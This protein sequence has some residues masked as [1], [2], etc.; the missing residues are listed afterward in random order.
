MSLIRKSSL[1]MSLVIF[2]FVMPSIDAQRL[3]P[4][5]AAK[6]RGRVVRTGKSSN[7]PAAYVRVTIAPHAAKDSRKSVYTGSDGMFYF[8]VKSGNYIL[9]VWNSDNKSVA[10][11]S[12]RVDKPNVDLEIKL[13]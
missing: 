9:E 1:L 5:Q 13:P 8:L 10:S 7:Y 4:D 11:Y 3:K 2:L 12:V 6:V